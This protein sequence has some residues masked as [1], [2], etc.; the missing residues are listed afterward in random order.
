M[1]DQD[2]PRREP[3]TPAERAGATPLDP[4]RLRADAMPVVRRRRRS[5]DAD[6]GVGRGRWRGRG[7][8]GLRRHAD[9]DDDSLRRRRRRRRRESRRWFGVAGVL[10]VVAAASGALA[11]VTDERVEAADAGPPAIVVGSPVLSARRAPELLARPVAARNLRAAVQPVL[12]AA[13]PDSCVDVRE[14]GEALV[15][16]REDAPLAPASNLKL[17]I[18]AA[19][20]ELIGPDERLVTRFATDGAPTD[21]SVVRGN[22]YVVGGGDPMLTTDTYEPRFP[23]G[24]PPLTD[25]EAVADQI[26]ATGITTIEGSVVGDGSRYDDV[27]RLPTWPERFLTQG[28]V[29]PLGA[30]IVNDG[31]TVH[32][33]TGV[34]GGPTDDPALHAAEVITLLLEDRGVE[35]L[36]APTTGVAPEGAA[37]LLEVPSMTIA[38][39]VDQL[40]THSDNTTTELLVKEIGVR[41]G[42]GG[43]TEAGLAAVRSWLESEGHDTSALTLED[44]SGLSAGNRVTCELLA[45]LLEEDGPSGPV[46]EGLA[47]PGEDGTLDDRMLE[48]PLRSAVR[49]KTGSLVDVTALSGWVRTQPG[50]DL[51]FA[52][53]QNT[54]GQVGGQHLAL[55]ERLLAELL[56]HPHAPPDGQLVPL[57]PGPP[58]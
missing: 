32:P 53:V 23:R 19:A 42:G 25:L 5:L 47:R 3:R 45:S 35:V 6:D 15:A 40:L 1:S 2:R 24:V 54:D 37:T 4:E 28:Q 20:L 27:R 31:W 48:E 21:G 16:H 30:L 50:R 13:P 49:A 12:D 41:S 43:S 38:E 33:L 8:L 14:G 18:G 51:A 29:G 7:R 10:A 17:V 39:L 52:F 56:G 34:G 36:G 46:S 22:L 26:V 44:G 9:H 55:Q 58:G 11:W 57:P